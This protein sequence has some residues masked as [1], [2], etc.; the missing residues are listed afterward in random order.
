MDTK[1]AF[2]NGKLKRK[3]YIYEATWGLLRTD[4]HNLIYRLNKSLYGLKQS[5]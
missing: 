5:P 1:T 2:L 3:R 4:K